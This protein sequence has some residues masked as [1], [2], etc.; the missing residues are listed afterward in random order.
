MCRAFT[1]PVFVL[2]VGSREENP[3]AHGGGDGG[4]C[5]EAQ[6]ETGQYKII[7]CL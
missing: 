1:V 2:S 5:P 6:G 4:S 3:E 7:Q